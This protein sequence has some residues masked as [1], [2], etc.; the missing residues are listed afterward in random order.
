MVRF[1][2]KFKVNSDE[3]SGKQ[4]S[5]E[6]ESVDNIRHSKWYSRGNENQDKGR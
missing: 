4:E 5:S 1:A 6:E 3:S 2:E